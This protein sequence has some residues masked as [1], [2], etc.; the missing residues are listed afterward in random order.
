M[1]NST[2]TYDSKLYIDIAKAFATVIFDI[3]AIVLLYSVVEFGF[4]LGIFR[5]QNLASFYSTSPSLRYRSPYAFCASLPNDQ[6]NKCIHLQHPSNQQS[7]S[8]LIDSHTSS[9]RHFAHDCF[10]LR[11]KAGSKSA[12]LCEVWISPTSV[13]Y[14]SLLHAI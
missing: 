3:F 4:L 7:L 8:H 12:Y 10:G 11:M 13:I 1:D 5:Y 14:K 2:S 9:L 6:L